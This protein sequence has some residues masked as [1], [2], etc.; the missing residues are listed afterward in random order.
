MEHLDPGERAGERRLVIE[1][2]W[3]NLDAVGERVAGRRRR[4]HERPHRR[5]RARSSRAIAEPV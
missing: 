2:E 1:L 4:A 5:S 3:S